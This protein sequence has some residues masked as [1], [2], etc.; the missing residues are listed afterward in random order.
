M[1]KKNN[2]LN[3]SIL[4]LFE[5][6]IKENI[7][8]IMIHIIDNYYHILNSITYVKTFKK[9]KEKLE[10]NNNR[11]IK[12]EVNN[13]NNER[14]LDEHLQEEIDNWNSE[15]VTD[16]TQYVNNFKSKR[17]RQYNYFD[18]EIFTKKKRKIDYK[19]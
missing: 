5:Y 1:E 19:I 7:R 16:V 14:I 10:G 2:L 4:D 17:A 6:I 9:L 11:N 15:D 8:K 13:N 18:A 12:I 3:S